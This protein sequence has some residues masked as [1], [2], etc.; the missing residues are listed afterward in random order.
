MAEQKL[1]NNSVNDKRSYIVQQQ[2][3][4][5]VDI[6]QIKIQKVDNEK[7]RMANLSTLPLNL[8]NDL[9]QFLN[10]SPKV[11]CS[12]QNISTKIKDSQRQ[13]LEVRQKV[14]DN[15]TSLG[16]AMADMQ[17]M[18]EKVTL[19]EQNIYKELYN[20][21]TKLQH[22]QSSV[23]FQSPISTT[24]QHQTPAPEQRQFQPHAA[25]PAPS[26]VST[27][28]TSSPGKGT[29]SDPVDL[30]MLLD[31]IAATKLTLPTL[32]AKHSFKTWQA[33]SLLEIS[34]SSSPYYNTLVTTDARG[35]I[36]LD[37][38]M[39]MEKRKQLFSLLTKAIT[40][41]NLDF[42]SNDVFIIKK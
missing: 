1:K 36:A 26:S 8:R 35:N 33:M 20:I 28:P 15:T 12:I 42:L 31:Y 17:G 6:E 27:C 19:V 34:N 16:K 24:V 32:N 38:N 10:K 21:K 29:A 11:E 22:Q 41:Q 13:L 9:N 23:T 4:T 40:Q 39:S 30:S 18:I 3:K 2:S 25:T 14:A 5:N 37:E 7:K